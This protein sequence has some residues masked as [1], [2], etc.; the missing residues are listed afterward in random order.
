MNNGCNGTPLNQ[1]Y[2]WFNLAVL[3]YTKFKK[4]TGFI[5][6]TIG[7]KS[8]SVVP[9]KA[10]RPIPLMAILSIIKLTFWQYIYKTVNLVEKQ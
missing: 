9:I 7:I 1:L 5:P 6:T 3:E 4:F 10:I 2:R 8:T